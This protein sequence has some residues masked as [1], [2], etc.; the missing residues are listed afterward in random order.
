MCNKQNQLN[1][2]TKECNNPS[3]NPNGKPKPGRE[4]IEKLAGE[5]GAIRKSLEQLNQEF[6]NSRQVLGRLDDIAKEMKEIEEALAD[7]NVGEDTQQRQLRI[8]S[9]MLQAS[10]SLQRRDYTEQR[11]AT[12]AETE[13]THIPT[14]LPAELLNDRTNLEDRLNEYLGEGYPEQYREQIRAYFKALLNIEAK[15]AMPAESPATQ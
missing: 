13:V 9:R 11:Q 2:Q 14:S 7:G 10:R 6:G 8:F 1:Q 5:Q 12:T 4:G 15:A 3:L